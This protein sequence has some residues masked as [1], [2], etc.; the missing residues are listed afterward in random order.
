MRSILLTS[1]LDIAGPSHQ[2]CYNAFGQLVWLSDHH[3]MYT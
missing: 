3:H 2:F 1:V